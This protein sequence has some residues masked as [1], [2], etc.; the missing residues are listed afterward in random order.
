MRNPNAKV[1]EREKAEVIRLLELAGKEQGAMKK[2]LV[3]LLTPSE[4]NKV[5]VRWQIIKRLAKGESHRAIAMDLHIGIATVLRGSKAL[6][7]GAGGFS[8]MLKK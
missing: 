1:G 2:I 5:A 8:W 3:D 4:M 7:G 6:E